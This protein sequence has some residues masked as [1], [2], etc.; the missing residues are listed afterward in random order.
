M[1]VAERFKNLKAKGRVLDSVKDAIELGG[2][3]LKYQ[4]NDDLDA[5]VYV[6]DSGWFAVTGDRARI[7][8]WAQSEG[9][10]LSSVEQ[11]ETIL[12]ESGGLRSIRTDD[13]HTAFVYFKGAG[14]FRREYL[15]IGQRAAIFK[16]ASAVFEAQEAAE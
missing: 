7:A 1:L 6:E 14:R 11:F 15:V 3:P 9:R 12:A 8:G 16:A 13:D 5:C 10:V 4:E 2:E